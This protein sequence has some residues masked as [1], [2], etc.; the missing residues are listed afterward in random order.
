MQPSQSQAFEALNEMTIMIDN[1]PI[2]VTECCNVVLE[3]FGVTGGNHTLEESLKALDKELCQMA[4]T[5]EISII[6]RGACY[7]VIF[8]L[9]TGQK[10]LED[11]LYE[12]ASDLIPEL[13]SMSPPRNVEK[14]AKNLRVVFKYLDKYHTPK[15]NVQSIQDIIRTNMPHIQ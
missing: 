8:T 1:K 14:V 15:K 10:Q 12:Y 13:L 2:N 3:P 9:C 4:S 6:M 11:L 7:D 5:G